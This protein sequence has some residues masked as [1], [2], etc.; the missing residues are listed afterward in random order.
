MLAK[1]KALALTVILAL[2]FLIII[3]TQLVEEGKA[4]PYPMPGVKITLRNPQNMTYDNSTVPVFVT[5]T[6]VH[7]SSRIS[8][9]YK[10]DNA[11]FEPIPITPVSAA[12]V[13]YNPPFSLRTLSGNFH[14]FNLSEGWHKITVYCQT[15]QDKI[16]SDEALPDKN[17]IKELL[18]RDL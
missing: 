10:L 8:F 7:L 16:Y 6:V 4:N 5:A 9:S 13:P 3:G 15:W 17:G 12:M 14:L 1:G 2:S 11:G 18:K